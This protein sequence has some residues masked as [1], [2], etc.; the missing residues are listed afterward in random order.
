[1]NACF[2][3]HK[4]IEDPA[5]IEFLLK[6]TVLELINQG[7]DTFLFGSKSMFNDLAH[8]IV[9]EFKKQY[10]HLKRVYVRSSFQY[11]DDFYKEYLLQFYE[12]T[13][14]PPKLTNAGKYSYAERN[15]EMIDKSTYCVFYYNKNYVPLKNSEQKSSLNTKRNSGT[16][17]A[18]MYAT[19]KHKRIINLYK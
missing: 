19:R 15:F 11:I 14:F 3:G 6:E 2:V 1:M 17:I 13:Y 10:P 8:A 5:H 4:V 9:T 18:Y 12:E 16:S 7:I